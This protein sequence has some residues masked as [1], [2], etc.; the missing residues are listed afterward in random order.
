MKTQHT[1]AGFPCFHPL[2]SI[3]WAAF[4]IFCAA[5]PA[6]AALQAFIAGG[7]G[8]QNFG[9]SLGQ[10]FVVTGSNAIEV[11]S[12]GAFDHLGDGFS[13]TIIVDLWEATATTTEDSSLP[14]DAG[15]QTGTDI[16]GYEGTLLARLTFTAADGN[17]GGTSGFVYKLLS[18]PLL[19][20][21]DKTYVISASGYN[22]VDLVRN[23]ATG[24][25]SSVSSP[26]LVGANGYGVAQEMPTAG[27]GYHSEIGAP[28]ARYASGSFEFTLATPVPEPSVAMMSGLG[29]WV[30]LRRRRK[31]SQ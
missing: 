31:E 7:D 11:T 24:A 15:T 19:L 22:A 20:T 13:G 25:L 27:N 4:A 14:Y 17:S 1:L 10:T 6:Q 16:Y 30:L 18:S 9:G 5:C 12:L 3:R 8:T 29:V 28:G 2:A 23:V 21:N 26:I